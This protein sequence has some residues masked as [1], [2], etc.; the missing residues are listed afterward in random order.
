MNINEFVKH[1]YGQGSRCTLVHLKDT[2]PHWSTYFHLKD[3]RA[4]T[5]LIDFRCD[6]VD[7]QCKR[8]Q[9]GGDTVWK[10]KMCCCMHCVKEVGYLPFILDQDLHEYAPLFCKTTGFWSAKGCKL[11]HALRSATCVSYNCNYNSHD[12]RCMD[13]YRT[14]MQD[15]E[16]QIKYGGNRYEHESTL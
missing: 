12:F 2:S 3:M 5:K 11:P 10:G 4:I 13:G 1:V 14:F 15:M 16:R 9:P 8:N 7:G 6:F